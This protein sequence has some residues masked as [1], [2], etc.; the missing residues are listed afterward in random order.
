MRRTLDQAFFSLMKYTELDGKCWVRKSSR[1]RNSG[2][3]V[4]GRPLLYTGSGRHLAARVVMAVLKGLDIEDEEAFICHTCDNLRCYN[5]HH[6]YI[7]DAA[8]NAADR[9]KR[10]YGRV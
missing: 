1:E 3:K 8:S 6:L 4:R 7:G 9:E 10:F 2:M 5:P